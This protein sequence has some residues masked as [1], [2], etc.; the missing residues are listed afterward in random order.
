MTKR[1]IHPL[2]QCIEILKAIEA[3]FSRKG[4]VIAESMALCS[5]QYAIMLHNIFRPLQVQYSIH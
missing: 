2:R 4:P 1:N 5:Q 3:M